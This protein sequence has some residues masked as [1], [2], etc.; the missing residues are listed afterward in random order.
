MS[1][2]GSAPA[3]RTLIGAGNGASP[4]FA[5]IGTNSGLTL[6]GV[7]IAQNNSAFLASAA[8]TNGQLLI[9]ATGADPAFATPTSSDGS[10]TFTLGANTLSAQVAGGTTV[11]K[12]ITGN[13]G[14]ALSPTSGNWNIVTS[15]STAVLAGSGSTLTLSFGIGNLVL[16]SS[17]PSLAGGLTNVGLGN[18]VL[19]ALT[20]G[21]NNVAVGSGALDHCNSGGTNTAIGRL[22]CTTLTTGS[23][24]VAVGTASLSG[25]QTAGQN[26]A[27]GASAMTSYSGSSASAQNIAIGYQAY[28]GDSSTTGVSNI[29]IGASSGSAYTDTESSNICINSAGIAAESNTIRIGTAGSGTGQQN[30]AF[31]AGITGVTVSGSAPTGIDTNG[32]LSS[33][34]FGT[35]GQVFTSNGAATSPT[36]Q[37]RITNTT[38]SSA[39]A[40][41]SAIS[42]TTATNANVT[43][44]SL[45]AGKWEVSGIVQ[46]G[47]SPTVSGAQQAS[48]STTS[49]THG[50]LGDN[51]VQTVWLTTAFSVGNLPIT[52][53]SYILTL[54]STT[55]VYLVAS[56]IFSAGSMTAYGRISAVRLN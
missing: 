37:D 52:I 16:G 41:G 39:I 19:N 51:S 26:V 45:A 6:H 34:G 38:A 54:G 30:R 47:G 17:L 40:S 23:N 50:T 15:N 25:M 28:Q 35:S 44:I 12:T 20:S 24:N 8:A 55:T 3:G 33:L 46:L 13:S 18:S 1:N 48:I 14:G 29:I 42:L 53:P 4:T 10:I 21:S 27:I 2:V 36:W 22:S 11:G 9:G 31:L 7:L 32:Q 43:S 49:A 56:G 5:A